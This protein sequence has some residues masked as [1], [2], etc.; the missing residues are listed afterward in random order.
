MSGFRQCSGFLSNIT[1]IFHHLY[2]KN[3]PKLSISLF[4]ITY[5]TPQQ[6]FLL[7]ILPTNQAL[8]LR[9]EVD[10]INLN[11]PYSNYRMSSIMRLHW[12]QSVA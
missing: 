1:P 9:H 3:G 6:A 8:S 11:T 2:S 12:L 10:M 4:Y 5:L 7:P